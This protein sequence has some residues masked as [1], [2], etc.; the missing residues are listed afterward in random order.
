[1][2][3]AGEDAFAGA[4]LPAQEDRGVGLGGELVKIGAREQQRRPR[5]DGYDPGTQSISTVPPPRL[6]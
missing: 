6:S 5:D 2:N 4:G 3:R 1:M